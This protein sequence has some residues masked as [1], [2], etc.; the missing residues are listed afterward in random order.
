MN[1][2]TY[3]SGAG[4]T[5]TQTFRVQITGHLQPDDD[6]I[7]HSQN[8]N[9][10]ATNIQEAYAISTCVRNTRLSSLWTTTTVIDLQERDAKTWANRPGEPKGN[11]SS[12]QDT[13]VYSVVI[14]REAGPDPLTGKWTDFAEDQLTIHAISEQK[15]HC[16]ANF[17]SR[18]RLINRLDER[19]ST[20]KNVGTT[21]MK[22]NL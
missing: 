22:L 4:K 14:I 15:A 18:S 19:L 8:L 17:V 2:H 11:R 12:E 7:I 6:E 10:R 1:Y 13:K 3:Y 16:I 20:K 5:R 21:K 9:I